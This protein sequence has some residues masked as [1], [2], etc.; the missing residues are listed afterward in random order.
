MKNTPTKPENRN[1]IDF[2]AGLSQALLIHKQTERAI[3]LKLVRFIG[4][5][6]KTAPANI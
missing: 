1:N 3:Y 5:S 4:F 6:P 2:T